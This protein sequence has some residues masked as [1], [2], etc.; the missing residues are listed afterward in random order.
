MFPNIANKVFFYYLN[1][2][3]A[4]LKPANKA[5]RGPPGTRA[6]ASLSLLLLRRSLYG[7]V[8]RTRAE[9]RRGA[10]WV[11]SPDRHRKKRTGTR[12][13]LTPELGSTPTDRQHGLGPARPGVQV[14]GS[15]RPSHGYARARNRNPWKGF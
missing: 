8:A 11:N 1:C 2:F 13:A 9:T 6:A 10:S 14:N 4:F 15:A 3:L 7:K 5:A 12:T